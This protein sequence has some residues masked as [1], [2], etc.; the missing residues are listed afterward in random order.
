MSVKTAIES[1]LQQA[2]KPTQ[3]E[4]IDDSARHAGHAGAREGGESHFKLMIVSDAF[5]GQ[6]RVQRH[7]TVYDVLAEELKHQVHALNII[8]KTPDEVG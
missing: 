5:A 3:L 7:R 6:S 8:A 4:L 2:L 1:K